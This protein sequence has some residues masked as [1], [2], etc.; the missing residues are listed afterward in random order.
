MNVKQLLRTLDLFSTKVDDGVHEHKPNACQ[1][2]SNSASGN[3][4]NDAAQLTH[5]PADKFESSQ[6]LQSETSRTSLSEKQDGTTSVPI[7][8][9]ASFEILRVLRS[10]SHRAAAATSSTLFHEKLDLQI[11][12]EPLAYPRNGRDW[13]F[14]A[15]LPSGMFRAAL[16]MPELERPQIPPEALNSAQQFGDFN[17][18]TMGTKK[19]KITCVFDAAAFFFPDEAELPDQPH[20]INQQSVFHSSTITQRVIQRLGVLPIHM[21]QDGRVVTTQ[22][23]EQT[24]TFALSRDGQEVLWMRDGGHWCNFFIREVKNLIPGPFALTTSGAKANYEDS[25]VFCVELPGRIL[26]FQASTPQSMKLWL[27]GL[28]ALL[29]SASSV[30]SSLLIWRSLAPWLM[31]VSSA[32]GNPDQIFHAPNFP[33]C[34]EN[35]VQEC[36][37]EHTKTSIPAPMFDHEPILSGNFLRRVLCSRLVVYMST[38]VMLGA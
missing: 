31:Q 25:S 10:S 17:N 20:S 7:A 1:D 33:P 16:R 23:L 26:E 34:I 28:L 11:P 9:R 2:I 6:H 38:L 22:S 21:L 15:S 12:S 32:N 18:R 35:F 13:A 29:E 5:P 8:S 24:T 19:L 4:M 3:S 30:V 14:C 36:L 27:V 37:Q